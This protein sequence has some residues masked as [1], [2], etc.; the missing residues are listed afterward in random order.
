MTEEI[1]VV[2]GIVLV[3]LLYV[4]GIQTVVGLHDYLIIRKIKRETKN[5]K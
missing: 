2:G 5:E 3:T 4:L 1:I